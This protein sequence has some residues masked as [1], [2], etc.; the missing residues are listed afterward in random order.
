MEH[1]YESPVV[2]QQDVQRLPFGELDLAE[3]A[4]PDE[5]AQPP[6]EAQRRRAFSGA[7]ELGHE[8]TVR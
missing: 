1:H 3:A 5:W 7:A 4:I 2:G 6:R 8:S